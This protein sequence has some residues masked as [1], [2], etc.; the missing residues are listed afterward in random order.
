MPPGLQHI[1]EL[2][3]ARRDPRE[4]ILVA[5]GDV[6]IDVQLIATVRFRA[7]TPRDAV[8]LLKARENAGQNAGISFRYDPQTQ[9]MGR[10]GFRIVGGA[11][12]I[13]LSKWLF[14]QRTRASPGFHR[15]PGS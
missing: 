13:H 6:H 4:S 8:Q 2:R 1:G 9:D 3:D 14:S 7:D 10:A 5:I 11:H 15:K 12:D